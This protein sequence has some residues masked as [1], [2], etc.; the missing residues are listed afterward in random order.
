MSSTERQADTETGQSS[1]PTTEELHAEIEET[2][3]A[4]G[5]TVDALSD[6]L[7]IKHRASRRVETVRREHGSALLAVAGGLT[8]STIVLAVWRRRR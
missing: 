8:L 2:R 4:L 6:K 5:E 7:D 3:Q 1:Q